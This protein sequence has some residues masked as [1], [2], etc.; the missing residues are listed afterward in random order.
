[1]FSL[2]LLN[3]FLKLVT[4]FLSFYHSWDH[5]PSFHNSIWE[6]ISSCSLATCGVKFK[7]SAALLVFLMEISTLWLIDA[8]LKRKAVVQEGEDVE[9]EVREAVPSIHYLCSR[10]MRFDWLIQWCRHVL[11]S[12]VMMRFDWL[13]DTIPK[14][15][16][17]QQGDEDVWLIDCLTY[18]GLKKLLCR[19][20]RMLSLR[21]EKLSPAFTTCAAGLWGLIDWYSVVDTCCVAGW[22]GLIDWCRAVE[23]SCCAGRRGC[24]VWGERSCP[25]CAAGW[26]G[27]IDWYSAVY[28]CCVAGWWCLI[29]WCRAVEKS[30]CAGRGGCWVWGERSCPQHPLLGQEIQQGSHQRHRSFGKRIY[31]LFLLL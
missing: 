26:G 19:K 10:V 16:V 25:H 4:V 14:T 17:V 18:T 31:H 3:A 11:C 23:K 1:M 29:D 2:C 6:E 12:R 5:V 30:C 15:A 28:R 22:G 20:E 21:W 7:G 8:E 9:F 24:W 27:L 13:I